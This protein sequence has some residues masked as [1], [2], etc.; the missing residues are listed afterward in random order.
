MAAGQIEEEEAYNRTHPMARLLLTA[1][2]ETV[3]LWPA[4][5][6]QSVVA[7]RFSGD[8]F[9]A[10][11]ALDADPDPAKALA[12]GLFVVLGADG[13]GFP[14]PDQVEF[15]AT[16]LSG[17][18]TCEALDTLDVIRQVLDGAAEM[19]DSLEYIGPYRELPR[20]DI[21]LSWAMERADYA[22]S[23]KADDDL[24]ALVNEWLARFEVPY[25]LSVADYGDDLFEL[26]LTR[27]GE[28]AERVNLSDV[29]F[30]V[31]Q[32]L[33]IITQLLRSREKTILVE[34][35]EAHVHPRL[36][37]VLGDLLIESMQDYGNRLI[38]ETHSEPVL[39]RLQ[40][41]VAEGRLRA[42]EIAVH[43]IVRHGVAAEVETAPVLANGQLD[44]QWPGGFFDDRMDDLMAILDPRP[45]E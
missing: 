15:A 45:D 8:W 35:P 39:L 1:G 7:N 42:D 12:A 36:Q 10:R 16:D 27:A 30:G 20:R 37:S 9:G 41:R 17:R 23:L 34:E 19:F 40:R 18:S 11:N 21:E 31:S 5:A 44:Y 24:V 29:G 38:I 6:T 2:E 32:L 43:H 28:S 33:P 25:T 22:A 13:D 26:D 14:D 4:D 3:A